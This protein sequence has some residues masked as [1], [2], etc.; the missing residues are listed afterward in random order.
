M[1]YQIFIQIVIS[2]TLCSPYPD[3]DNL[4]GGFSEL[5]PND[6]VNKAKGFQENMNNCCCGVQCRPRHASCRT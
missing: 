6:T 4:A 1:T 3:K 2:Y 5:F